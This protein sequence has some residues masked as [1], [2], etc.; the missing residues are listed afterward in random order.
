M[1][2]IAWQP[3][4]PWTLA[5]CLLVITEATSSAATGI[6]TLLSASWGP[7]GVF[8]SS[9]WELEASDWKTQSHKLPPAGP[10][11]NSHMPISLGNESGYFSPCPDSG[12]SDSSIQQWGG[13]LCPGLLHSCRWLMLEE[14]LSA[15]FKGTKSFRSFFTS[16]FEHADF[17]HFKAVCVTAARTAE[18]GL[19]HRQWSSPGCSHLACESPAAASPR[20]HRSDLGTRWRTSGTSPAALLAHAGSVGRWDSLGA[21]LLRP[22]LPGQRSR[23]AFEAPVPAFHCFGDEQFPSPLLPFHSS[24]WDYGGTNGVMQAPAAH[25]H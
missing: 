13:R 19:A 9:G 6:S 4:K 24:V 16:S 14:P 18:P 23:D 2:N 11:G 8:Q 5:D 3:P 10:V 7:V 21:F 15:R 20:T 22:E 25:P 12:H 1:S 17:S